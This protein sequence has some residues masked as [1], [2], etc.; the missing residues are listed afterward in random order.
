[1]TRIDSEGYRLELTQI[2]LLYGAIGWVVTIP[3]RLFGSLVYVN[4]ALLLAVIA[5]GLYFAL[6]W[7][8][9]K[10][11]GQRETQPVDR[12]KRRRISRI[13]WIV[14]GVLAAAWLIGF[15]ALHRH[16]AAAFAQF[17]SGGRLLSEGLA[18]LLTV[19]IPLLVTD[20]ARL[21]DRYEVRHEA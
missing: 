15:A 18:P 16:D 11:E 7:F 8:R 5:V 4:E 12:E 17:Y 3:M 10:P 20:S 14:W 19:V 13:V 2:G 1:M 9:K 6:A 21:I